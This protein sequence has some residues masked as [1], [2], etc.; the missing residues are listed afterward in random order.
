MKNRTARRIGTFTISLLL[1]LFLTACDPTPFSFDYKDTLQD[2][3]RVELVDYQ[4]SKTRQINTFVGPV[5]SRILPFNHDD[6]IVVETLTTEDIDAF[7]SDL[8]E[9]V[10]L[11][12]YWVQLNGP[13]NLCLRLVY[14]NGDFIILTCLYEEYSLVGFIGE[15]DS[16]GNVKDYIGGFR[17]VHDFTDLVNKYFETQLVVE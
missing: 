7:V 13:Q 11:Y 4:N 5:N 9:V 15:Y 6:M 3:V 10:I 1:L 14:E 12:K 17:S 16:D 8:S 2:L